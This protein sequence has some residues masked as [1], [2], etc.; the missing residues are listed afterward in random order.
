MQERTAKSV[1]VAAVAWIIILG[2]LAVAFKFFVYPSI[3]GKIQSTTG[4]ESQYKHEINLAAD[5]FSGYCVFRSEAFRK[6]LKAAGIKLTVVN[7]KADY[8]ARMKA[9]QKGDVQ[10][11]VFTLDALIKTGAMLKDFP[12]TV[13]L[14]IDETKGADAMIARKGAVGSLEDLNSP[15]ARIVLTPDSPSEFL[16]RIVIAHFSLPNL[17]EKWQVEANGADD[18][19]RSFKAAKAGEKRA[20]VLW[21][22]YVSKALEEPDTVVLLDSSRLKGYIVDVLVVRREFLREQESLVKEVVEDYF[23]AAFNYGRQD[24]GMAKLVK[25]DAAET[26]TDRL[27]AK[28]A[29]KIVSGIQWKNTLENYAHFGLL[30]NQESA[31]VQH[32]EDMVTNITD[33]LVKTGAIAAD[34]LQGKANTLYY[35]KILRSLRAENFH[36]G[37][38][39][40]IIPGMGDDRDLA[41]IRTEKA[42]PKLSDAQWNSLVAVGTMNVEPIAF[43]RGTARL[44][45]NSQRE[46]DEL[47]GH[48]GSW[49]SYY[50]VVVGHARAEG[51]AD[52]NTALA[53]KRAEAAAEY[54]VS[55][56]I[57]G[58]R[59]KAKAA[60]AAGSDA[61][62]QSVSFVV[63]QVPY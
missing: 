12:A 25:E 37:K 55:R 22:P 54:L 8:T 29:E 41:Q 53:Q 2:A 7:D 44:N 14:V 26:G 11:A 35:D 46:L 36:P 10:M 38:N 50:L 20:F 58:N 48:L 15:D 24:D 56:G 21:E 49:P 45:V 23:R 31:G 51:D 27:D 18:V 59:I 62:E 63:G 1:L 3:R 32:L 9:L 28:L 57:E 60:P 47:A 42:L 39:L 52:A 61:G 4:S 40:N 19:Y 5:S 33:V 43:A 34:P 30:S 17:P 13:V 16:A 6:Q